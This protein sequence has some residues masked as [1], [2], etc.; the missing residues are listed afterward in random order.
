MYTDNRIDEDKEN[1]PQVWEEKGITIIALVIT[2]I[3]L[4]ILSGVATVTLTGNNRILQN[5]INTQ[6]KI[7]IEELIETA[8]LDIINE[9]VENNG[10]V[11][12]ENIG[13]VLNKYFKDVPDPLPND[14]STL[15]L[16]AKNEYGGYQNIEISKIY[17]EVGEDVKAY[18]PDTLSIG[19]PV[20][21][22]KY[23][24]KVKN[25]TVKTSE[26]TTGVWRLFYQDENYAYLITDECIGSYKPIEK[27]D[28]KYTSGEEISTEGKRLNEQ[29]NTLFTD[30]DKKSDP[31]ILA[32]VWLT[33]T[34]DNGPWAKYKNE[35]A[36]FAI[37]SP[38]VELFAASYNNRSNK[39]KQITVDIG[40]DGYNISSTGWLQN[41]ENNGVYHKS[42]PAEIWLASPHMYNMGLCGQRNAFGVYFDFSGIDV[43]IN[44]LYIRPIVC[45]P[46]DI[47]NE[48]YGTSEN[49]VNE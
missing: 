21:P 17:K 3:I 40:E 46:S 37:G 14:L 39:N 20:N 10:K 38:S 15:K 49:L 5:S 41:N 31:N 19:D 35:D 44:S 8:K 12:K 29:V 2:I 34:S 16:N 47:F 45:I 24:W 27:Y 23:G 32:T 30:T 25:Y 9:Q 7:N 28:G 43:T 36:V 11:E 42:P 1:T 6:E 13:R 4:L 22:D 33:D 18:N 48:K 26:F